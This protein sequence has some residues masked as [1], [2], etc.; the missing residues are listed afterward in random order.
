M[1]AISRFN[2][3]STSSKTILSVPGLSPPRSTPRHKRA[4]KSF[5]NCSRACLSP[6]FVDAGIGFDFLIKNHWDIAATYYTTIDAEDVL[7]L[8]YAI[9]FALTRRF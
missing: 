9:T 1:N 5:R 8:D 7:K 2:S 4:E 6:N 3:L